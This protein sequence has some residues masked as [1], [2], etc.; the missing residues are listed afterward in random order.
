MAGFIRYYFFMS[1]K[2]DDKKVTELWSQLVEVEGRLR[3][4]T[5]Q[6]AGAAKA[7]HKQKWEIEYDNFSE[8]RE[9]Y[10]EYMENI[11]D[12]VEITDAG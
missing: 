4:A 11:A 6:L 2:Y 1:A 12:S 3:S 8:A 5:K 10:E 7:S 9:A